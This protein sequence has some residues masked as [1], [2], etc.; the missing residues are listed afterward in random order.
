MFLCIT[1]LI[2]CLV[3]PLV[4]LLYYRYPGTLTKTTIS[5]ILNSFIINIGDKLEILINITE[6][7]NLLFIRIPFP[8]NHK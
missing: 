3:K 4:W 6:K 1:I 2:I 7:S 5:T 8:R